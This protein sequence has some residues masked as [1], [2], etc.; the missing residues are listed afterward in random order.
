MGMAQ[1]AGGTAICSGAFGESQPLILATGAASH[2]EAHRTR[3]TYAGLFGPADGMAGAPPSGI[4]RL[5]PENRGPPHLQAPHEAP[6]AAAGRGQEP[7]HDRSRPDNVNPSR[8]GL[9]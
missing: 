9:S 3:K 7:T 2:R 8:G 5:Q 1:P 4:A 6:D